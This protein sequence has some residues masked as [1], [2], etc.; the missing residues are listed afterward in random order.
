M[1]V[2]DHWIC[3]ELPGYPDNISFDGDQTFWLALPDARVSDFEQLYESLLCVSLWRLPAC[4]RASGEPKAHDLVIGSHLDGVV[5]NN[6]QDT[7]GTF[8]D[9]TSAVAFDGMLIFGSLTMDKIGKFK[10]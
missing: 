5:A 7:S 10:L 9:L 4:I 3:N 6:L 1:P 2:A 8:H